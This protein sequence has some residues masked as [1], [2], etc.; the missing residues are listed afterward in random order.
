[1]RAFGIDNLIVADV[2]K[3]GWESSVA[4]RPV[5]VVIVPEVLEHLSDPGGFLD[6]LAAFAFERSA[7][8]VFTVPSPFGLGVI[9]SLLSNVEFVHPDHNYW[10]SYHTVITLLEKHGWSVEQVTPYSFE[11]VRVVA[12]IIDAFRGRGPLTGFKWSARV[13]LRTPRRLL[14]RWLEKRSQFFSD[15]LI[16]TAHPVPNDLASR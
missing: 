8:A 11:D 5:D 10:F 2:C 12:P 15:G 13:A 3:A 7:N 16:V 6:G 9:G 14:M 4:D 1:M